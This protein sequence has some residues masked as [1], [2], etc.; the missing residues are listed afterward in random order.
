MTDTKKALGDGAV[1]PAAKVLRVFGGFY[2]LSD[3]LLFLALPLGGRMRPT[4]YAVQMALG[5]AA[6][7]VAALLQAKKNAG[8]SPLL[9]QIAGWETII[10]LLWMLWGGTACLLAV[11]AGMAS[12]RQNIP[13]LFDFAVCALLL[14]PLGLCLGKKRDTRFLHIL[15]DAGGAVFLLFSLAAILSRITGREPFELFG[16]SY[17][18]NSLGRLAVGSN[19]N[20]TG[21]LAVFFLLAGLYRIGSAS[22]G[23]KL[24][25]GVSCGVYALTLYW[26]RCRA[27]LV[28]LAGAGAVYVFVLLWRGAKSSTVRKGLCFAAAGLLLST[29]ILLFR[30]L[31][32]RGGEI[33]VRGGNLLQLGSRTMIWSAVIEAL[34]SDRSLLMRGCSPGSVLSYVTGLGATFETT[35]NTHNQFLEILI[36]QGLP[37]LTLYTLWLIPVIRKGLKLLFSR[38]PGGRWL[39]PLILVGL[40][41]ENLAEAMLVFQHQYTGCMFFLT[42]GFICG[43]VRKAE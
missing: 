30:L 2:V 34:K 31:K 19:P 42:A 6:F 13:Y 28:A 10:L 4:W 37:G 40:L 23:G 8:L 24:W 11:K 32:L 21:A 3:L 38:E 14:F 22:A 27:G 25:W 12:L 26:S 1:S 17:G 39:L 16:H 41:I 18:L 35:V 9:R 29:G 33:Q 20:T 5:L 36:G 15:T 7:A 43:L